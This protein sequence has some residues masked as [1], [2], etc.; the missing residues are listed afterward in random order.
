MPGGLAAGDRVGA[1]NVKLVYARWALLPDLPFRVLVFMALIIPDANK[2]PRYWDRWEALA[3]SLG[4]VVPDEADD[5]AVRLERQA[6]LR[7]VNRA[8]G[9]LVRAKAV[10][11]EQRASPG[12]TTV[13]RL[14]LEMADA[15]RPPLKSQPSMEH[16]TPSVQ[17]GGRLPSEHRTPNVRTP[18]A[19]RPSPRKE[20]E[21]ERT[22][23]RNES[24]DV[25]TDVTGPRAS[26]SATEDQISPM[27][28]GRRNC[29]DGWVKLGINH[30]R[31]HICPQPDLAKSGTEESA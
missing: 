19:K 23:E 12:R 21:E 16:R 18:D 28:C 7:A 27:R 15:Y 5:D 29:R 4:R 17:N 10:T 3:L 2:P 14:N 24:A 22:E 20:E 9:A 8:T 25:R 31:C 26:E 13:Y 1:G 11:V 30:V 6:A